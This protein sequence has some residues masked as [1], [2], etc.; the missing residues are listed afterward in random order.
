[1]LTLLNQMV[2]EAY[3][4]EV[5]IKSIFLLKRDLELDEFMGHRLD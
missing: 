3:H 4:L 1:M 2:N 5:E